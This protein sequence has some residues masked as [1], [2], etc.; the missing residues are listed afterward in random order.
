MKRVPFASP[1]ELLD[2]CRQEAVDL[3][4]EYMDHDKKQRQV[5]LAAQEMTIEQLETYFAQQSVTAY[6]RKESIFFEVVA[7]WTKGE[8]HA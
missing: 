7:K 2:H 8:G 6:Y 5:R 1:D 4:I 3:I